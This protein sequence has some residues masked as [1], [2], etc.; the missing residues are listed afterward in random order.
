MAMPL[1]QPTSIAGVPFAGLRWRG[2]GVAEAT[3]SAFVT[4]C[5]TAFDPARSADRVIVRTVRWKALLQGGFCLRLAM[6]SV[7][8]LM[9]AIEQCLR[10]LPPSL[11]EGTG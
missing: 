11:F 2:V 9:C 7:I 10:K 4:V 6:I 8:P 5:V 1:L 3:R